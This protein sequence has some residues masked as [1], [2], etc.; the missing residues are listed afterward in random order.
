ME[1]ALF[2]VECNAFI[3]EKT[4]GGIGF[5]WCDMFYVRLRTRRQRGQWHA[6]RSYNTPK[7]SEEDKIAC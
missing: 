5:Y 4:T 1:V 3:M 6:V 7:K 2:L